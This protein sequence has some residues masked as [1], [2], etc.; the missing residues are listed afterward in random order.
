MLQTGISMFFTDYSMAPGELA[1]ALEQRG[2][3]SL[4]APDIRISR[5]PGVARCPAAVNCRSGPTM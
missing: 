3:E 2:L 4:W 5:C 1:Q